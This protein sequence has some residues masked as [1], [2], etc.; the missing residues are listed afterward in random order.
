MDL[1]VN[2]VKQKLRIRSRKLKKKKKKNK[3]KKQKKKKK[4]KKKNC[5][6][7]PVLQDEE[8]RHI[9]I[10]FKQNFVLF[11]MTKCKIIF[12]LFVRNSMFLGC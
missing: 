5:N 8:V 11:P 12:L 4:K 7:S 2:K 9:S 1:C 10:I 3:E 6:T